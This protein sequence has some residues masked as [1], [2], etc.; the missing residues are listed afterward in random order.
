MPFAKIIKEQNEAIKKETDEDRVLLD[1]EI[2]PS[3]LL[4]SEV[5]AKF[6]AMPFTLLEDLFESYHEIIKT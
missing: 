4:A 5:D 3:P 1:N 2:L 6:R